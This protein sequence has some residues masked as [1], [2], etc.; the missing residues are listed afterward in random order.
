MGTF[1]CHVDI[2]AK[3]VCFVLTCVGI[4]RL[5]E[6]KKKSGDLRTEHR[7]RPLRAKYELLNSSIQRFLS[8]LILVLKD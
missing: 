6:K 5:S 1:R 7:S 3:Q 2:Q 8:V 4:E